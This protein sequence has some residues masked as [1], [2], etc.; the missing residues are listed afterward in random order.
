MSKGWGSSIPCPGSYIPEDVEPKDDLEAGF[1]TACTLQA[2]AE[3]EMEQIVEDLTIISQSRPQSKLLRSTT[4]SQEVGEEGKE[5]EENEEGSEQEEKGDLSSKKTR[6]D[7][8]DG[9][10]ADVDC[11]CEA[12]TQYGRRHHHHE[13]RPVTLKFSIIVGFS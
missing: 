7:G 6:D 8:N 4:E 2:H 5:D 13:P 3:L 9:A 10:G 12:L 1:E 11:T